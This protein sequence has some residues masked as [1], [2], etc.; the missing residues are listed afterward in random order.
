M[1]AS[2]WLRS[3]TELKCSKCGRLTVAFKKGDNCNM[4]QPNGKN[5][6]GIIL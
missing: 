1:K 2:D 4:P 3:K 5:C 6:K